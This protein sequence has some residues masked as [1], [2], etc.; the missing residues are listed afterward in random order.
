MEAELFVRHETIRS[1][2]YKLLAECY[3]TPDEALSGNIAALAEKLGLVCP[4]AR[5]DI[6]LGGKEIL[7]ADS[8]EELKVEYA[9]LFVGP[10]T[11]LAPPYGSVYLEPGRR[12]MGNS[13]IDVVN[14]YRQSGL[15]LAEDFKDAPDHIAAE[16]EFMHFM[17]LKAITATDLGD[18]NS[19]ITWLLN[20]QSFLV[21]HLGAWV[22]EFADK[23]AENAKTTFYRNLARATEAFVKDDYQKIS[24][25][26]ASWSSN[27][28]KSA[29]MESFSGQC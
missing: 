20:R 19:T 15:V 26:L 12:I 2:I 22:S 6:N 11:L 9:R 10:Y 7:K 5:Q 14:R 21:D 13:T 16:L 25:V 3:Y 29:E 27:P 8:I 24:S 18:I 1:E 23:V 17:I 28:E 4:Q